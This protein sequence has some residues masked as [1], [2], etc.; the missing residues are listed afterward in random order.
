MSRIWALKLVFIEN[1][2]VIL[3][4]LYAGQETAVRTGHGKMDCF[5]IGKGVRQ[6]CILSTCLFNLP[7]W[8]THKLE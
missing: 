7:D 8:K 6:G 4:H 1:S 5:S 2:L 3:R